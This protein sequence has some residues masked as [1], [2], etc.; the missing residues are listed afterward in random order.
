[1]R[2]FLREALEEEGYDVEVAGGGRAGVARLQGEVERSYRFDN[3]TGR[4]PVMQE[5]FGMV[6]CLAGSSASVLV[7]G[8]SGTGKELVARSIHFSSPRKNLPFVP[9]NCA[10][11]PDTLL[12]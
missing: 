8:E 4:S 12:E 10:A 5:I 7:T 6:R 3:I 1:M 11:I 2:D 9:L